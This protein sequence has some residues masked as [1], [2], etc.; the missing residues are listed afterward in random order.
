[1]C[2]EETEAPRP[3]SVCYELELANGQYAIVADGVKAR[4]VDA[5]G[6]PIPLGNTYTLRE[7]RLYEREE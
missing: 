7:R 1:L 3:I 5:N 2:D 6:Q 4:L